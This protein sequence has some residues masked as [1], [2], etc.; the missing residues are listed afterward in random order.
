MR[1]PFLTARW[2]KLLIANY[3]CDPSLL[4]DYLPAR[5][6]IDLFEGNCFISLVAFQFLDTR[7]LG[8]RFPLHINFVE[9]NLRFYVTT[10]ENGVHKRGV[11][12]IKEIVPRAMITF[13]ANTFF[14]ENYQTLPT[15]FSEKAEEKKL[16]LTYKWGNDNLFSCATG[17]NP[18]SIPSGSVEEFITEH[19]W[20]YAR[21]ND[22]STTEY[23]VEHPRWNVYPIREYSIRCFFGTLYGERFAP[24]TDAKPHSVLLAE[25]SQIA[26]GKGKVLR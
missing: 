24:L 5:T 21:I 1:R 4:K 17:L 15:S 3:I 10:Q 12:F 23:P 13:V 20:G 8:I 26:V 25:G 18:Q 9:V 2:E 14:N 7:V 16:Q 11:V 6:S 19:Y 22:S